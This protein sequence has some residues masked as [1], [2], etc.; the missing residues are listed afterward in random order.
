M[1]WPF[2]KKKPP[3]ILEA[4]ISNVYGKGPHHKRADLEK[5]INLAY[6][7]LLLGL[8]NKEEVR[9]IAKSL[10]S[11][12][13]P[14]STYDLALSVALNFF[15]RSEYIPQLKEAQIV[16]RLKALEWLQQGLVA[17]L[18]LWAFEESL[19]KLYKPQR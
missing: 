8:I 16:A 18:L 3:N 13:I 11:A 7:E 10:N 12:P 1:F 15:R 14:Y 9:K 4:V 19:Y 5:A 17:P 2:K 6:D